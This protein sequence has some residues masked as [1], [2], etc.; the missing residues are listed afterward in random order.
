MKLSATKHWANDEDSHVVVLF[1]DTFIILPVRNVKCLFI[2][3]AMPMIIIFS[4]Y[5]NVNSTAQVSKIRQSY[6]FMFVMIV[7]NIL[8]ILY[9]NIY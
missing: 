3:V 2:E 4:H 8:L 7:V 5:M 1:N 6:I 9:C